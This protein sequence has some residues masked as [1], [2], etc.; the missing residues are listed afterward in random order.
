MKNKSIFLILFVLL[1][2]LVLAVAFVCW[3]NGNKE[4]VRDWIHTD[5]ID[6]GQLVHQIRSDC[7]SEVVYCFND[8]DCRHGCQTRD[9]YACLNGIC[10]NDRM[11]LDNSTHDEQCLAHMGMMS[12]LVGNTAFGRYEYVCKS[13]D[14]GIAVSSTKNLMCN[15]QTQ[16][17]LPDINYMVELP[18]ETMCHCNDNETAV[19]A[20]T[21]NKR[22]HTECSPLADLLFVSTSTAAPITQSV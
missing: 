21:P 11:L 22:Q 13:I 4:A 12:Y 6:A 16:A 15:N 1:V 3:L 17:P 9:H 20:A 7:N 2:T 8:A 5:F 10:R 14:P 18:T 19:V